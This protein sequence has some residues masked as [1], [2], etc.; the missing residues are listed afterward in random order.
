VIAG[1]LSLAGCGGGKNGATAT[2]GTVPAQG[3]QS[4][5]SGATGPKS[6]A[7]RPTHGRRTTPAE[8]EAIRRGRLQSPEKRNRPKQVGGQ[9][10]TPGSG[11]GQV[12]AVKAGPNG[13]I[14][15]HGRGGTR[16]YGPLTRK[17]AKY[18]VSF[19]QSKAAPFNVGVEP[20]PLS[21]M[22]SSALT[23][24]GAKGTGVTP[25]DW[26]TFYVVVPRAGSSYVLRLT[27]NRG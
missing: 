4:G 27:P 7:A 6:R 9:Q 15:I 25:I 10:R 5:A 20:K 19:K 16:T 17:A 23:G 8:R 1:F 2:S 24:D 11:S 14:V 3:Q 26:A 12:V 13:E 22:G 21:P 18:N